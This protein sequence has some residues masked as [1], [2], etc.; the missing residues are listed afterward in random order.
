LNPV[1]NQQFYLEFKDLIISQLEEASIIFKVMDY[2]GLVQ[3]D[4][5][6]GTF[7]MDLTTVY[8]SLNHEMYQVTL[9]L[10]DPE[11]KDVSISGMLKVNVEVLGPDDEP[12]V[13]NIISEQKVAGKVL[14][15]PRIKPVGHNIEVKNNVRDK[16]A[17]IRSIYSELN[18]FQ[19]LILV[20]KGKSPFPFFLY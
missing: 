6:I 11:D 1:Y 19:S 10:Y 2:N 13:H 16:V 8:F 3:P 18:I 9:L 4:T 12:N 14:K 15:P 5:L 17:F 20:I 7:E